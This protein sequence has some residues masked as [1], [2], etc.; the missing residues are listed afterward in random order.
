MSIH[1][2]VENGFAIRRLL[3]GT[4]TMMRLVVRH[5]TPAPGDLFWVAETW[6]SDQFAP[7]TPTGHG[8]DGKPAYPRHAYEADWPAYWGTPG[9]GWLPPNLMPLPLSRLT[10][11]VTDVRRER[12]HNISEIDVLLEGAD[13]KGD[14]AWSLMDAAETA[15]NPIDAY[16]SY[17]DTVEGTGAWLQNPEVQVVTF[18]VHRSN[19]EQV[20]FQMKSPVRAAG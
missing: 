20:L 6:N 15:G 12:L 3:D 11:E 19:V 13:R 2:R 18:L 14:G 10:L 4:R 8:T 16:R 7:E 5:D 9:L 1:K 17:W